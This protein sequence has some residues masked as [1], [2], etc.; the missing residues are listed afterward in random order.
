MTTAQESIELT[1]V[2]PG[3]AMG[4]MMRCYWIPAALSSEVERDGPPLRFKLLGEKL[5]A[6]RD[7]A[8]RVGVMDHRCPHRCASLFLGRNEAGGLRC[9]Y[10]GWKFDAA[11]NCIDMPSVPPDRDFK[12]KVKAKA[13]PA[14]E[15]AGV[16]WVYMGSRELPP[17]PAFEILDMPADEV[18]VAFVMRS[19]NYLQAIDGELDTSHFGFLHAGHVDPDEL[20]EDE[21]LRYTVISRHPQYH[22]AEAP[23]GTQYAG[24]REAAP[25]RTYWRFANFLFPFWTQAPNG[26]FG[27]HMHARG[28]VP[29]DDEHTMY[30]YFWWQR[31]RSSMTLGQPA[32]RD[33]T[34]IGGTGRG[35]K[36]LPNTTDWLG[37]FRMAANPGNDWMIDREA[38]RNNT[39][40]TGIDG[41]HLQD[42]AICESMGPIVDHTFEHLAP[43]DIMITRTR[44]RLLLASR[45]LREEGILPP[46]AEDGSVYR[47]ARSGYVITDS[48]PDDEKAWR[49]LYARLLAEAVRAPNTQPLRAAE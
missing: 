44:R 10:H 29:L 38:Q 9:V 11:G 18:R 49:E 30:V 33:G 28:W 41:V 20:S 36:L 4:E 13:Y 15:K 25:G 21:P 16:I 8:G 27:S 2:G 48:I 32:Y 22:L 47:P 39:I 46:G 12:Q 1:R 35:N 17:L 31:S 6:F 45:A 7:S 40:Y 23:W 24:Y 3:T 37:R 34:P 14:L 43:S 19:C 42:Q 5:I 26:E